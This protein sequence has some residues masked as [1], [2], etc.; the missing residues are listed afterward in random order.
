[1][2]R[3]TIK[4]IFEHSLILPNTSDTEAVEYEKVVQRN[5]GG[6]QIE[7]F[8]LFDTAAPN[9]SNYYPTANES[10]YTAAEK[11]FIKPVYR[12]LSE[13]IVHRKYNPVDFGMNG[14]LKKS[15]S[16]LKGQTV[17]PNHENVV[18]NELGAVEE[19]FW[20]NK[21]KTSNGILIPAGINARLKLDAKSNPKIARAI[22]MSPPAIHSTSATVEFIWEKSH[23]S[24]NTDEFFSKLGT[25]D[26]DGNMYRRIANNIQRYHELSLVSK[27]ADPFAQKITKEG[28]IVNPGE[29]DVRNNSEK[30]RD[31]KIF[32]FD[33][34]TIQN[35][36]EEDTIPEE[37]IDINNNN[38]KDITMNKV[39]LMAL[40]ATFGLT[41]ENFTEEKITEEILQNA[42]KDMPSQLAAFSAIKAA[43]VSTAEEVTRLK[44]AETELI[45]LKESTKNIAALQSFQDSTMNTLRA[46]TIALANKLHDGTVPEPILTMLNSATKEVLE[47]LS[48]QYNSDIEKK[49]P[50]S[51]NDCHSHNVGRN[52]ASKEEVDPAKPKGKGGKEGLQELIDSKKSKIALNI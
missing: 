10:D 24:M 36:A 46:S 23:E 12:A 17:Y 30:R 20:E 37:T 15:L 50:L 34:S 25:F 49:F 38:E 47:G 6:T 11:D 41:G 48:V 22:N 4:L 13:V 43:G 14:V 21:Y 32:I 29:A 18:G 8:G 2:Y 1:M 3:D 5:C 40:A 51:C 52:S 35:S 45:A 33:F 7:S 28:V 26:K 19:V 27:G 39:F 44:A 16:K 42:L 31:Q 9:F